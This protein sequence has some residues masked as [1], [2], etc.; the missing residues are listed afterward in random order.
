MFTKWNL[1]QNPFFLEPISMGTLEWFVGRKEELKLCA[2]LLKSRGIISIEGGLGVGT[3]SFGNKVRF[4]SKLLTPQ[5]EIAIYRNWTA[6]TLMENVLVALV[7]TLVGH[8]IKLPAI[9]KLTPLVEQVERTALGGGLSILGMGVSYS[10]S[11]HLT[12]PAV[13]PWETIRGSV[14]QLVEELKKNKPDE[15]FIIQLNN[16]DPD[17]TFTM[18]ELR[19]FLNDIRDAL[20]LAGI[21][22]LLIG[23]TGLGSF[24]REN[25]PR[26]RSIINYD[27]KLNPLSVEEMLK[28]VKH[29]VQTSAIPKTTPKNPIEEDLLCDLF[30]AT[31]G[32]LREVF[33]VC[34]KLCHLTAST[35]IYDRINKKLASEITTALLKERLQTIEGNQLKGA[36]LKAVIKNPGCTQKDLV[37]IIKK[38]QTS[39]SRAAKSLIGD[40]YLISARQGREVYYRPSAEVYLA[41]SF[42][43][44]FL[45]IN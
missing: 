35:A 11:S 36:I 26:L 25:V 22:W 2:G 13:V 45:S 4:D 42:R 24:I 23:K 16:L 20:Q 5:M 9:K 43:S 39:I 29:R 31:G 40:N 38:G 30:K 32:S 8:K 44:D 10:K 28:A 41:H 1:S 37:A 33:Q 18:E 27:L 15:G 12:L 19:I 3:T 7:K 21:S 6:Q 17:E 34:T 14:F